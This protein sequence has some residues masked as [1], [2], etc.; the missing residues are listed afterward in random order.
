MVAVIVWAEPVA[1]KMI[2]ARKGAHRARSSRRGIRQR[3]RARAHVSTLRGRRTREVGTGVRPCAW[4]RSPRES[5]PGSLP[6]I[7]RR[8]RPA[9]TLLGIPTTT[10]AGGR[11]RTIAPLFALLLALPAPTIARAQSA[12]ASP[13]RT[14]APVARFDWYNYSGHDSVYDAHPAGK[15]EYLNPI[16]SGFYPDPALKRVGNDYYYISSTFAYFP[17]IPI[18]RSK[19]LVNWTQIGNVIHRPEQLK[20]DSLGMSRGVFAPTINF[21]DGT[22]YVLNTCVDCGGNYLVTA[23]NPAGP[24][25]NPTWIPEVGGIDPSIFFD[26]D[27]KTYVINNDAPPGGSTYP[28]HRA[29]WIREY[30]VAAKRVSGPAT[31]I[32]NGGV[33]LAQ[34]PLWLTD[35][36]ID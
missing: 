28:G 33:D 36:H 32:I 31:M 18:F 19:D 2:V 6:A 7:L 27:G 25:S 10:P 35:P 11:L 20:F 22:F 29:I 34:K 15:G 3:C 16:F 4:H 9:S 23:T 1:A 17:G 21:H 12:P 13:A 5:G 24:W 8:L 30:D 26:D 14:A